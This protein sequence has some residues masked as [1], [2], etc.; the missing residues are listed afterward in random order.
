MYSTPLAVLSSGQL[1]VYSLHWGHFT[2][3]SPAFPPKAAEQSSDSVMSTFHSL[4]HMSLK[5]TPSSTRDEVGGK[6]KGVFRLSLCHWCF[7]KVQV[8]Q[9]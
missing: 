8:H 7:L 1:Q 4:L 5:F 2:G 9:L 6:A 3:T